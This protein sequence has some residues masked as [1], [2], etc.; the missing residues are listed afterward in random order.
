MGEQQTQRLEQAQPGLAQSVCILPDEHVM[1]L[2]HYSAIYEDVWLGN[3]NISHI[4]DAAE[5]SSNIQA[6]QPH[7]FTVVAENLICI[8]NFNC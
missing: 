3:L 1:E 7:T 8:H 4:K 2:P 6:H 5:A